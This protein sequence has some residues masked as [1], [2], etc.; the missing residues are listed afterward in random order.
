MPATV[1]EVVNDERHRT[2][3]RGALVVLIYW[4]RKACAAHTDVMY[5]GMY[6]IECTT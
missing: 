4:A 6:Y 5:G 2:P 1:D 3:R